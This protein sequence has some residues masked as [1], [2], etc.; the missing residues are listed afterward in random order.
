MAYQVVNINEIN[1]NNPSTPIGIRFPFNGPNGIF[2]S[3][4]T[5]IDQTI[6][7]LKSLLLTYKGERMF[8]PT[9]GTDLPRL[10]FEPNTSELKL[11]INDIITQPVNYWLPYIT[12][13]DIETTTADDD[14]TLDYDVVIKISFQIDNS[15][16]ADGLSTITIV[17]A[18]NQIMIQ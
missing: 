6:S 12:I 5:S 4:F 9:F 8:Q 11:L 14:D 18:D 1:D 7:N 3:T 2:S 17:A 15:T 13:V 10:I 16:T